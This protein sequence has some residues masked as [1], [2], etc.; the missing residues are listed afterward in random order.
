MQNLYSDWT[1]FGIVGMTVGVELM[2]LLIGTA[3]PH[4]RLNATLV[5]E[6]EHP[7]FVNVSRKLTALPT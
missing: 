6:V 7:S 4:S 1:L 5:S 2:I 3:V